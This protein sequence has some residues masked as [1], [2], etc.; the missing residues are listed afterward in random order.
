M[1]DEFEDQVQTHVKPDKPQY[2]QSYNKNF[3]KKQP[4]RQSPYIAVAVYI[5]NSFPPE[6]KE[7]LISICKKLLSQK[8]VVRINGDDKGAVEALSQVSQDVEV[9]IPWKNF[10]EIQSKFYFNLPENKALAESLFS[11]WEKVPD[12]VKAFLARNIRM[13]F[14]DKNNN[15][16]LALVTWSED[17]VTLINEIG[18]AT[19][20]SSFV[21][22]AA[23]HYKL[24]VFNIGS[25]K[26]K[27]NLD[28][29]LLRSI[30]G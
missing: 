2:N 17:G 19:G 5:D 1:F 29:S 6:I 11:A 14:G 21:L 20:K 18:K 16:V 30:T 24:P 12:S 10:N 4:V 22:K 27:S 23:L 26:S 3:A 15:S 25:E 13:L 9:Y 28:R 8:Y 7:E